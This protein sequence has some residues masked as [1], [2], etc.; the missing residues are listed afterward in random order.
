MN[1]ILQARL[2]TGLSRTEVCKIL[3]VPYRTFENWERDV[4]YPAPYFEKLL[5]KEIKQINNNKE[6][7]YGKDT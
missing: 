2:D 6:D 7:N 5:I 3:E 4:A 1:N